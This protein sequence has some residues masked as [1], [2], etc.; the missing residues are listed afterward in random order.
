MG[1]TRVLYP[2]D[3]LVTEFLK[4]AQNRNSEVDLIQVLKAR[5]YKIGEANVLISA[6]SK[7]TGN[8][9][10][11]FGLNYIT[12]EEMANLDNPFIAFI[13]GSLDKI[14]ILPASILFNNLKS[15]SHDRNGE[16][17]INLDSRLNIV[18]R[19][20]N[21]RL[22]CNEYINAW[23]LLFNPPKLNFPQNT[24]EDSLHS[25][26]QGRIIEIGN[27]RGFQTYCPNKSKKFNGKLLA[28]LSTIKTCPDLQFSDYDLLKQ[29]DVL[30]FKDKNL[31]LIPECAFEVEL[32]T[33]TWSGVGRMS[34]LLDY[35]E[36]KLFVISDDERK[37]KK[38]IN[39]LPINF[40]R[41]RHIKTSL[42]GDLYSAELQLK[43]LRYEIGL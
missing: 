43:E 38:V 35:S 27:I 6:A 42:I 17:K 15:I 14:L 19:G 18:L 2:A 24:V 11:F 34:T 16:Y 33:G 31:H 10:Y 8:N 41:Y 36:T 20:K 25:V 39:T 40:D 12:V 13:C 22:E 7:S 28:D 21:N 3:I 26:L 9:R 29:I 37:Y 1:K 4:F 5:V 30:W 32:S 23:D